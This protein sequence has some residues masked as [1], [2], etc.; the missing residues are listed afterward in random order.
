MCGICGEIRF[1]GVQPHVA[2]VA[3][4]RDELAARGPDG[5]GLWT[6][7]HVAFGHRRLAIID[8]SEAGE[9]PMIDP[10]LGLSVVFN[11]CIYNHHELRETLEAEGYR[12]FSTS[13]TEVLLKAY[14][15]WGE[16]FVDHL[17]GMFA[18]AILERDTGRV[19][20]ARDRLGIKPL[21]LADVPGALRFASSLP[22][23]VKGGDIDTTIDPVALHHYLTFHAV[24]PEPR[25]ILAGVKKLPPAT[26]LVVEPDGRRRQERYWS[27]ADRRDD[28]TLAALSP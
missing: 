11:G 2:S 10:E 20:F 1:D 19:V 26:V 27:V 5:S 18:L 22:A 21:Y 16:Q 24:V 15:H 25:T 12:F 14:H 17:V 13:D 8:L 28:T 23:L 3:A 9:Q 4:M 6:S 7:G